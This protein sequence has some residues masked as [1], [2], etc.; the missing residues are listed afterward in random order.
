MRVLPAFVPMLVLFAA[1]TAQEQAPKATPVPD[2]ERAN[3]ERVFTV[4]LR[5]GQL[6]LDELLRELLAAYELDGD[7][8]ELPRAAIDLRGARATV[9][10]G[11][12]RS[13]LLRTVDFRVAPG[14]DELVVT[15]DRERARELR[16]RLRDRI[17]TLAGALAGEEV[18]VR[19]ATLELPAALDRERPLV[20]LVHG[21]ESSPRSLAQL[22]AFLAARGCQVAWFDYP[23]D[24]A[25]S[26]VAAQL[27]SQLKALGGQRVF[28]VAH[29]FGGLIAR[30]ALEDPALDPGNV[31]RLVL[32]GVPNAGSDL[33]A[34]RALIEAWHVVRGIDDVRHAARDLLAS[35]LLHWTDGR[36]EAGGD[37]LPGSVFLQ[38]LAARERNAR[39]QYHAVLGT[40]SLLT[41]EQLTNT[42]AAV[43]RLLGSE[44]GEVVLPKLQRWLDDLD[45]LVDGQ[46]DGAVSVAAGALPG[47]EPVLVPVDHRGL[48]RT[49]GL[50]GPAIPADEHPVFRRV[51]EW[52]SAAK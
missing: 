51:A 8:L 17:A 7:A 16:R 47:V 23:N 39:V 20:V 45:E 30:A 44:A 49:K 31:Q 40:R 13:V 50:L 12:A 27:G 6:Q 24:A 52:V 48:V 37:L 41:E 19:A 36:G 34:L 28:V 9:V 38:Q 4:P 22:G 33:A 35:T 42:T 21:I 5:D 2:A 15:I 11:A 18:A 1:L 46:G 14:G 32:I 25:A 10:L 29:S 43:R 3:T 26:N